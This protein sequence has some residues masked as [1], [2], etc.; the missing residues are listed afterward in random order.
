MV[1][2]RTSEKFAEVSEIDKMAAGKC[3]KIC[4]VFVTDYDYKVHKHTL[5]AH[6]SSAASERAS[7]GKLTFQYARW[8]LVLFY[9]YVIRL[10]IIT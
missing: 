9:V 1:I 6:L 10:C 5:A 3:I 8:L 4:Q 2:T 7:A